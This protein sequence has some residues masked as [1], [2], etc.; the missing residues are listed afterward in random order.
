MKIVLAILAVV[1]FILQYRL[2]F[3][4]DGLIRIWNLNK[5]IN[6]QQIENENII[7][8]NVALIREIKSLKAGGDAIENCARNDLG[9]VKK[10]EI[11]YQVVN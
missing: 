3:A 11:F 8:R 7:K 1:I 6:V 4:D 10:G 9:M 2:W 5:M